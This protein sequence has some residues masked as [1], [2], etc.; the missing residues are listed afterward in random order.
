MG[1]G[2]IIKSA[3]N[4][5]ENFVKNAENDVKRTV[6]TVE[7]HTAKQVSA[8]VG[9]VA[10]QVAGNNPITQVV[11]TAQQIQKTVAPKSKG[12]FGKLI[13]KGSNLVS[14]V[15]NFGND[16]IDKGKNIANKV[17]DFGSKALD[18]GKKALNEIKDR[19]LDIG[20]SLVNIATE[21]IGGL[22]RSVVEGGGK[23]LKGGANLLNPAPLGKLFTGD[24]KGAWQDFKSNASNGAK[25]VFN[26]LVQATIQGPFDTLAV[27]LQNGIS[28]IQTA[29]GVETPGRGLNDAE[30]AELSKVYGDK[31][32]LSQIRIKEDKIG[33]NNLMA[34]HTVGNTIYLPKDWLDKTKPDYNQK[35]NE[36]L[37]HEAAHSWQYQNGG[38][39]YIG[40]SLWNQAKGAISGGSRDAAYNFADPIKQGKSWT[41]LNPEQQ[42]HLIDQAY[43]ERL[44]D[45]PNAKF[46]L[47][48][49]TDITQ[50]ARNAM[51][52]MRNGKG[53]A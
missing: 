48:D 53:A 26:G 3:F 23:I 33:L 49:G 4:K 30:K 43:A 20:R 9:N 38:T 28:A 7:K 1:I 35:R 46:I 29:I 19:G 22:G 8:F 21:G 52:Q 16:V 25:N 44:F 18:F 31:L 45:D 27:G 41:E 5:A 11:N 34:P 39:D 10:S 32:D 14:K 13:D 36:L 2:G 12:F 42:A 40:A 37:V 47:T 17:G 15:G 24:F 6:K 51:E 50:Y